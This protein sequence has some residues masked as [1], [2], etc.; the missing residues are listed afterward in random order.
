MPK[1]E[2]LLDATKICPPPPSSPACPSKQCKGNTGESPAGNEVCRH[3]RL[4]SCSSRASLAATGSTKKL[5][6]FLLFSCENSSAENGVVV[7]YA[8][9][10]FFFLGSMF[11]TL[12][13]VNLVAGTVFTL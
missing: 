2:I 1:Q 11:C 7:C 10:F 8:M 12:V 9:Y 5:K 13:V 6:F 3:Q 4:G